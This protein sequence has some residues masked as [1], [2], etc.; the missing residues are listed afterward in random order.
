[1]GKS[2]NLVC[3]TLLAAAE[4]KKMVPGSLLKTSSSL[5]MFFFESLRISIAT[6]PMDAFP[7]TVQG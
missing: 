6:S 5:L 3:F 1:M 4:A 2:L 7:P